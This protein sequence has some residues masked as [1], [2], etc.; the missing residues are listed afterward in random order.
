MEIQ[1]NTRILINNSLTISEYLFLRYLYLNDDKY[2]D[3]FKI[4]D[5]VD[6]DS[7]Q[8]RGFIRILNDEVVLR[9]KGIELFEGK[10]LFHKF[11][12]TY[13]IKTPNGRYLSP[14][15]GTKKAEQLEKKWKTNLKGNPHM[16]EQAL[17]VLEG[18]MEWRR[19]MG[20]FDFMKTMEAWINQECWLTHTHY[21]KEHK[22]DKQNFND[23]M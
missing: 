3:I 7:L 11:L 16:E 15:P 2:E 18:E 23:F 10:G 22:E 8:M 19:K 4:I 6:E 9:S 13:P 12:A 17:K 20:N 21:L 5:K 14:G 1:L